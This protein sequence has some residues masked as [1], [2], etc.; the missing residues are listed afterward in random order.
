MTINEF[1]VVFVVKLTK[2]KVNKGYIKAEK[3]KQYLVVGK[4]SNTHTFG[5]T[6]TLTQKL[7]LCDE[8]GEGS[9]LT[10]D[11]CVEKVIN[12]DE[13]DP[14]NL[15]VIKWKKARSKWMDINY[16]PVIVFNRYDYLGFPITTSK[17]GNSVLVSPINKKD[18][19]HWLSK[20]LIHVE[21][22]D[23]AFSS[24]LLP[25]KSSSGKISEAVSLRIP[26][27]LSLKFKK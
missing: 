26:E 13:D 23:T 15:D 16:V 8:N 10:T 19:K 21:D 18:T 3:G 5:Y 14:H 12:I 24:S 17:D 1:D 7:F 4:Y 25:D 2:A 27:W 11:T 9:Y 20:K 6:T 22:I